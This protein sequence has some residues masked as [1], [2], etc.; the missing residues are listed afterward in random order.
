MVLSREVFCTP[1]LSN[2]LLGTFGLTCL[3]EKQLLVDSVFRE[4]LIDLKQQL[5]RKQI[6]ID[7]CNA[8]LEHALK[9]SFKRVKLSK[10][11]KT[12]I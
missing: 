10:I 9:N 2:N 11:E 4:E 5:K 1:L 7:G 8:R 3:M 6:S 12:F